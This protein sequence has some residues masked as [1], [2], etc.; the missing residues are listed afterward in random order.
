MILVAV[1]A[2]ILAIR[3]LDTYIIQVDIVPLTAMR[4]D[5][6]IITDFAF[7]TAKVSGAY[8]MLTPKARTAWAGVRTARVAYITAICPGPCATTSRPGTCA[9]SIIGVDVFNTFPT[10]YRPTC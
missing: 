10:L 1:F 6:C 9:R 3:Q 4:A 2:L 5:V 8:T 7:A